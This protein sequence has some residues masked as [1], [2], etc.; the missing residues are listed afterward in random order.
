MKKV[1]LAIVGATTAGVAAAAAWGEGALLLE[2]GMLL[3]A[4]FGAAMCAAPYAGDQTAPFFGRA[5]KR[6]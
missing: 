2:K 5:W 6:E 1:A 4:E 3:G